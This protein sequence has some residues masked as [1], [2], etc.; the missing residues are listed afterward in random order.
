M[1]TISTD[2]PSHPV[3][4]P[5][6][7]LSTFPPPPLPPPIFLLAISGP[8]ST[9]KTTLAHLLS[10]V[11]S[12]DPQISV[13][14]IL[15]A[16]DFCREI[17]DIPTDPATGYV[18]A[19]GPEGVNFA[20][21]VETLDHVKA[22]AK[23]GETSLLP[24]GFQGWYADAFPDQAAKAL[25]MVPASLLAELKGE[26]VAALGLT[27]LPDMARYRIVILEGFLLYHH[28][29]VRRRLDA[30]LFVRLD[31]AEAKKRRFTRP[32]YGS[33]EAKQ[34]EFWKTED[35]FEKMVWKNYVLAHGAMFVGGD[36]E[37]E[38]DELV[39]RE[40]GVMVQQRVN[41]GVE[42]TLRWAVKAVLEELNGRV[43]SA[44]G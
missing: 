23:A 1:P 36:V 26:V 21:M 15:H 29:D 25:G 14:L 3:A 22:S 38:V 44:E 24:P 33:A 18:D 12:L 17:E 43:K 32:G 5:P 28:A 10:H 42:E 9:G 4:R 11:F 7:S 27:Q 37:G 35:Y 16:D 8:S 6:V 39:A 30:K 40:W 19:D 2:P 31:H 34:D 41:Q 13:P 20:R